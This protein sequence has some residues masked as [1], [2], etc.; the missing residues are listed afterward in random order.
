MKNLWIKSLA[1]S[2]VIF[3]LQAI[4][5]NAE[6]T[7]ATI[8]LTSP[9]GVAVNASETRAYV[10]E[11]QN[12]RVR[13]IDLATNA[14]IGSITVG[15][16]PWSID[17]NPSGTALYV[18][19][20]NGNS[21]SVI[22]TASNTVT[23]TITGLMGPT[24]VAFS[25]D[26][27]RAFVTLQDHTVEEINTSNNTKVRNIPGF[28]FPFN[29]AIN[30]AGTRGYV[31][32]IGEG[33]VR[34][35]DLTANP[36]SLIGAPI[37]VGTFP[38][39]IVINPSGTKA[40]VTNATDNTLSV[41]DLATNAVIGS[42][43]QIGSDA[44]AI[45][46]DPAGN[47]AYVAN[48]GSDSISVVDLATNSTIRTIPTG[49]APFALTINGAGTRLYVSARD[50]NRLDVFEIT[51]NT[52][53][54]DSQGGSAVSSQLFATTIPAAPTAPTRSGYTFAGWSATSGGSAVSFPYTPAAAGST[55]LFALWTSVPTSLQPATQAPS[56]NATLTLAKKKKYS[57]KALAKQAGVTWVSSKAKV[58]LSVSKSSK[59]ICTKSGS[60]LRTLKAGNC[61]VTFTVQEPKPKKGPKP[62]ATKTA[63][64]FV[65]Q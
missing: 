6:N 14:L 45:A 52:V 50:G 26:G 55:S 63:K 49:D 35:L 53:T 47:Y 40:Y 24:D 29:I 42:P 15:N 54:F 22:D 61:S 32:N 37:Q 33:K 13:V 48:A 8:Q 10:V 11:Q 60:S 64:A 57:A 30:P 5:A 25:P 9:W 44:Q 23:A 27:T 51:H 21:V 2:M 20:Y 16:L 1:I 43:I 59:K 39:G 41:I 56:A 3:G 12:D 18:S 38:R 31:S 28:Y 7:I 65:I 36:V 19:N 4:P 62:K 17:Q 58:T 46:M 34:V